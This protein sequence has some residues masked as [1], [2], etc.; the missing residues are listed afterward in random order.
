MR[1]PFG[2]YCEGCWDQQHPVV[3]QYVRDD[4]D[5]TASGGRHASLRLPFS[6]TRSIRR[7]VSALRAS[8][9]MNGGS[10]SSSVET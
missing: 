5:E 3:R 1:R 6:Q 10:C 2:D 4:E 9:R 8:M 7:S